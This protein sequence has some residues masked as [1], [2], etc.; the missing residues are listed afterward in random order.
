MIS[1]RACATHGAKLI[2]ASY[3]PRGPSLAHHPADILAF[4]KSFPGVEGDSLGFIFFQTPE[5]RM[6]NTGFFS[7][8]IEGPL[9]LF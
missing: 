5:C 6:A 8:P 7:Q 4:G 2:D 1:L 9:L 3:F